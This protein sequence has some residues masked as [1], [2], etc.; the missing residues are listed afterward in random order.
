MKRLSMVLAV[1]CTAV[2]GGAAWAQAPGKL[3]A[4]EALAPAG[5]PAGPT[6][7]AADTKERKNYLVHV[8]YVQLLERVDE[9]KAG[10]AYKSGVVGENPCV[11]GKCEQ[12]CKGEA[13]EAAC[14]GGG[15]V[16]LCGPGAR[17][18]FACSGGGCAQVFYKGAEGSAACSGGRCERGVVDRSAKVKLACTG[19]GCK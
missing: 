4:K 19:G 6:A 17:C 1:A 14:P 18:A 16:Q 7:A 8:A 13:C 12:I 2:M 3:T 9:K 15:C 11:K 10:G 5:K